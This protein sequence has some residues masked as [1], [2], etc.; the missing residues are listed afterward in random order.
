MVN[1]FD[2]SAYGPVCQQLLEEQQ[3]CELG[4]G[5][6]HQVMGQQLAKTQPVDLFQGQNVTNFEMAACCLSGLWLWND[7]LEESHRI[8]QEISTATGSYWHA[9]MHRREPDFPNAKYWFRQVD[10][11]AIFPKLCRKAAQIASSAALDSTSEFLIQQVEWDPF[12]FTDL[13][14]SALGRGTRSEQL[15]REV[16]RCEWALLFDYCF[17]Q[18]LSE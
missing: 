2:I 3:L 9:M 4:P 14:E 11:H 5:Q 1:E 12:H 6:P 10:D 15:C 8:S 17:D 13:C 16:A 18:A 7:F